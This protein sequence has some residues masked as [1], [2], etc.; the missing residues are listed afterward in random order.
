MKKK[1][2]PQKEIMQQLSS[3]NKARVTLEHQTTKPVP[4]KFGRHHPTISV[5]NVKE[6]LKEIKI[7]PS[8]MRLICFFNTAGHPELFTVDST[9]QFFEHLGGNYII[10][11]EDDPVEINSGY[12]L[13]FY[14]QAI[15][16]P[17]GFRFPVQRL[18]RSSDISEVEVNSRTYNIEYAINPYLVKRFMISQ[19]IEKTMQGQDIQE[20]INYFKKLGIIGIVLL[21]VILVILLQSTGILNNLPFL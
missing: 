10:P 5:K 2:Q 15:S 18:Q 20:W 7:S 1:S 21:G 16:S 3:E 17:I 6:A 9:K 19:I 8:R 4:L 14:H 13:T 12:Q 11:Q